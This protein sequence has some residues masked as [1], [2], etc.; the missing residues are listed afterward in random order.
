MRVSKII[1]DEDLLVLVDNM[2]TATQD[3]QLKYLVM[4]WLEKE[5]VMEVLSQDPI[6]SCLVDWLLFIAED[7]HP[8]TLVELVVILCK[9]SIDKTMLNCLQI[10]VRSELFPIDVFSFL[11]SFSNRYFW[12]HWVISL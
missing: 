3:V 4:N 10:C 6:P 1:K 2:Y 11:C 7:P 12:R 9:H 8:L 5:E